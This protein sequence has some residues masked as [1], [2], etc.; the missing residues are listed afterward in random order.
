MNK[1]SSTVKNIGMDAFAAIRPSSLPTL[2]AVIVAFPIFCFSLHQMNQLGPLEADIAPRR[3]LKTTSVDS[4]WIDPVN[5]GELLQTADN[6]DDNENRMNVRYTRTDPRFWI[7]IHSKDYDSVRWGIFD[8]GK[9]Y[10][11]AQVGRYKIR[12]RL[13]PFAI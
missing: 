9:Y 11:Q 1:N 6:M 12:Q 8:Y 5:C 10:E 4:P 2:L 13:H 3:Q 7:S